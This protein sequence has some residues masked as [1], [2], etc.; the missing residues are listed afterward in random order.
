MIDIVIDALVD[1]GKLLPFLFLTYLVM[2][3]VE[4]K[5]S[6]K[7]KNMI[8][9]SGRLGP[10]AGGILGIVP[11]CGF[12]AAASNLYAGR[13]ITTGTLLAVYLSTSDEM[14]PILISSQV[15]WDVIVKILFIKLAISM[16]VGFLADMLIHIFKKEH[17]KIQIEHICEHDHC[18]CDEGIWQS[19][20]KHTI[21]ITFFIFLITLVLN[22]LIHFIGED[23]LVGIISGTPFL[24]HILAGMVGLIPNCATSVIITQLYVD[25][26]VSTGA[27]MAGL[28]A[29]AGV[30]LLVLFRV[31]TKRLKENLAIVGILYGSG[32]LFGVLVDMLGIVL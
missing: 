14:L 22:T 2:E 31:N 21:Y 3:Y 24:G 18:H 6:E 27:M 25:G 7:T 20:L 13:I 11:Q 19:A 30:G 29:G 17:G 9:H 10:V 8:K 1:S 32:V 12:S 23:F 5:T 28:L 26:V 15:S 4:H 16:I